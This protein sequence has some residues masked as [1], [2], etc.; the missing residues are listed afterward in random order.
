MKTA[1]L[2]PLAS[3]PRPLI[4]AHRG[5]KALCPENTLAAFRRALEDGADIIETDLHLTADGAFVCIHD[6]TVDRT[7]D[8]HGP[9]ARMTLAEIRRL[10]A[11]YGR[12]EFEAERIPGLGELAAILPKDVGIALELKTDRF[13]EEAV[14]RRLVSELEG[15]GVRDRSIVLSFSMARLGAVKRVA[16]DIPA[17][18]ITF[19]NPWPLRGV[20]LLGLLWPLLIVNPLYI[21]I[22]HRR[23]QFV[24]PLDPSPVSRMGIYRLLG[25]DAVL[26]DDPGRAARAL[27]RGR[28]DP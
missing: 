21:E 15:Y 5:N 26:S 4:V 14:C 17:G 20:E 12:K 6:E 18:W 10:S 7:T 13:L 1:I 22:A 9:V 23:G 2:A 16:P 8:G 19:R 3:K 28:P 25:C 27:K 11:G 24:C